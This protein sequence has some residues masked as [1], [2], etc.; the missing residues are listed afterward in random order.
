ME[1]CPVCGKK[2]DEHELRP[3][4]IK[5]LNKIRKGKFHHYLSLKEFIKKIEN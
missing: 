2:E 5:K 4:Y 3:E 1:N